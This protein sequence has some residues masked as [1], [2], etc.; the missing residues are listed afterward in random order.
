MIIELSASLK[1]SRWMGLDLPKLT[2]KGSDIIGAQPIYNAE[3]LVSWQLHVLAN[4]E[5]SGDPYHTVVAVQPG[6]RYALLIPY[7]HRPTQDQLAG[8]LIYRWGNELMH[9]MVD[10]GAIQRADVEKVAEQFKSCPRSID[11]YLNSHQPLLERANSAEPWIQG[12]LSAFE[13]KY[14]EEDHAID[15]GAHI[16][17]Q[18]VSEKGMEA[19]DFA[20]KGFANDGLYRFASG[21]CTKRFANTIEGDFPY[22]WGD[23]IPL[24]ILPEAIPR[25]PGQLSSVDNAEDE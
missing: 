4:D 11:W 20:I 21:L 7:L 19:D 16:N 5:H 9:R 24:E 10:I 13:L 8:D 2:R 14:L 23:S 18:S 17:N 25:Y 6:S 3:C 1:L 15:I 12:Y 22:P